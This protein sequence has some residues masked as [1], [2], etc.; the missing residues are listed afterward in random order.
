M[1]FLHR[2]SSFLTETSTNR[3]ISPVELVDQYGNFVNQL[4]REMLQID[5]ERD[6]WEGFEYLIG[7]SWD[8]TSATSSS[9]GAFLS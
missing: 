6:T 9:R 7:V 4:R 1:P 8:I 5:V 2:L 3:N